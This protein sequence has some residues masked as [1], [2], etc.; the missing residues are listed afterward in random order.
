MIL[1]DC[2]HHL[3]TSPCHLKPS[4]ALQI[5]IYIH[6][7]ILFCRFPPRSLLLPRPGSS[8]PLPG[9][10]EASPAG[11]SAGQR[12]GLQHLPTEG[13][14]EWQLTGGL[15]GQD[16]QQSPADQ[17]NTQVYVCVC[18]SVFLLKIGTVMGTKEDFPHR[19]EHFVP[20]EDRRSETGGKKQCYRG[21]VRQVKE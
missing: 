17:H 4:I 9:W 12:S 21:Y 5:F 18:V 20:E 19:S 15:W 2:F 13:R 11:H 6:F 16:A 7:Q 1:F 8:I 10:L 3:M 14:S